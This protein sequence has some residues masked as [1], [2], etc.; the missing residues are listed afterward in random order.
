MARQEKDV[1]TR[2]SEVRRARRIESPLDISGM[3]DTKEG[4]PQGSLQ[5][6]A[7]RNQRERWR[8]PRNSCG[9]AGT[10]RVAD[11]IADAVLPAPGR[12]RTFCGIDVSEASQQDGI[13]KS[14]KHQAPVHVLVRGLFCAEGQAS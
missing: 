12:G 4:L 9:N 5:A 6:D 7:R 2:K 3:L 10:G 13:L 1:E 8:W 11:Q 14:R